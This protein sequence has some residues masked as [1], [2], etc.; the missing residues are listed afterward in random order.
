MNGQYAKECHKGGQPDAPSR[1]PNRAQSCEPAG[2]RTRA[3]GMVA[4]ANALHTRS[5]RGHRT[6]RSPRRDLAPS[7]S[8]SRNRRRSRGP[9]NSSRL[10]QTRFRTEESASASGMPDLEEIEHQTRGR[11]CA[12]SC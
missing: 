7:H 4:A 1:A 10:R 6:P 8:R 9:E 5:L 12:G 11:W 2:M 3:G